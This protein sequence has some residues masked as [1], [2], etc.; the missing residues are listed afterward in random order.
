MINYSGDF[1]GVAVSGTLSLVWD[2][3]SMPLP[4]PGW[5]YRVYCW[6]V[7][8]DSAAS[9]PVFRFDW[10]GAGDN[11]PAWVIFNSTAQSAVNTNYGQG[12]I[13]PTYAGRPGIARLT[14]PV[15]GAFVWGQITYDVV[16][17]D[18]PSQCEVPPKGIG[19]SQLQGTARVS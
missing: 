7:N 12:W 15:V 11:P 19:A 6:A 8:T 5:R 13:V 3:S 14:C 2:T 17:V 9:V 4:P 1:S 16:R 18:Y 10:G